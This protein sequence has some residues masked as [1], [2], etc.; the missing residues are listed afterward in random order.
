MNSI[1]NNQKIISTIKRQVEN[2]KFGKMKGLAYC[3]SV[4]IQF[5]KRP[6]SQDLI[7]ITVKNVNGKNGKESDLSQFK[8]RMCTI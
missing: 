6:G 7:N 3:M 2:C 5:E 4:I 8:P 1:Q